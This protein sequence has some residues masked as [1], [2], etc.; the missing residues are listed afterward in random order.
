[1]KTDSGI[2]Q[3]ALLMAACH[4]KSRLGT[5]GMCGAV[6]ISNTVVGSLILSH[7]P[8]KN[9]FLRT[10]K[11]FKKSTFWAKTFTPYLLGSGALWLWIA[12]DV[13]QLPEGT[14]AFM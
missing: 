9:D 7:K 14:F 8:W 12:F 2:V 1:M 13:Y 4:F 11:Y 6:G 10:A 5:L 3:W